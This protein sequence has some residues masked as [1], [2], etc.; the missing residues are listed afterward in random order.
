MNSIKYY[1]NHIE[2]KIKLLHRVKKKTEEIIGGKQITEIESHKK[3]LASKL[4]EIEE[5]KTKV[6]DRKHIKDKKVSTDAWEKQ[7]GEKLEMVK[8]QLVMLQQER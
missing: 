6:I 7:L 1:K 2:S 5:L 4:D 8:D 3:L